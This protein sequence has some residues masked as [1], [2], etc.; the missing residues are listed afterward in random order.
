MIKMVLSDCPFMEFWE[1][2]D[3]EDL[4]DM[5]LIPALTS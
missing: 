4:T 3:V 5:L 2:G 1:F